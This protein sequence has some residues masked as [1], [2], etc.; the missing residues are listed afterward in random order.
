MMEF[1]SEIKALVKEF[2]I[3]SRA[4]TM[5]FRDKEVANMLK[6]LHNIGRFS[7]VDKCNKISRRLI[8]LITPFHNTK[9]VVKSTRT[10]EILKGV[11]QH[12]PT[13]FYTD[14]NQEKKETPNDIS[15]RTYS[16]GT[17]GIALWVN[18][19]DNFT[20][21]LYNA[22][23]IQLESEYLEDLKNESELNSLESQ[24]YEG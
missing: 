9:V 21:H 6:E 16:D 5:L 11:I 3:N 15:F 24:S 2:N 12:L 1:N 8:P 17:E 10:G 19:G 4:T 7:F 23:N 22:E 14:H 13:R 18:T 20:T